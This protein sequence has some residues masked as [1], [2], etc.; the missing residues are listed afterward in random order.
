MPEFKN[1]AHIDGVVCV[2]A[3]NQAIL[4]Q[5]G[6]GPG[7]QQYWIPQSQIDD[8][9]EVWQFGDEGTLVVSEWIATEKGLL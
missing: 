4:I 5:I 2:R 1:K 7:R 6:V 3:T 9:S 8:D